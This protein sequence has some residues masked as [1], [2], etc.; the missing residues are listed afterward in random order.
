MAEGEAEGE[1]DILHNHPH[2]ARKGRASR[3][4]SAS[5][6]SLQQLGKRLDNITSKTEDGTTITFDE[7]NKLYASQINDLPP[8]P[9]SIAKVITKMLSEVWGFDT[10]HDYQIR[11]IFHL[12]YRRVPLAYLIRKCG[13]G[14]SLVW[15]G[16]ATLLWG[17]TISM[18]PLIGLGSDQVSKSRQPDDRVEAYQVDEFRGEDYRLLQQRLRRYSPQ[19]DSSIICNISPQNLR[20]TSPWYPLLMKLARQGFISAFCI[21]EVHATVENADSFRPEF[22]D[23]IDTINELL[24]VSKA[25]H[26]D[27]SIPVLAMSA[28]FRI[29]EQRSFN[30]IM[31][32]FPDMVEWGPMDKRGTGIFTKIVGSVGVA[33]M[34][35]WKEHTSNNDD[36]QSLIYSNSA[37]SCDERKHH[38]HAR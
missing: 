36:T 26:P 23:G 21:D 2:T 20:P 27:K 9:A 25:H 30:K 11:M 28:T 7:L 33:L 1:G 18:V 14:K 3:T 10:P 12:V 13:E 34:N 19:D 35:A 17:I 6:S 22:K 31:G 16:M 24:R 29:P 4:L 5:L 38:W 8:V 32:R 15:L 37:K